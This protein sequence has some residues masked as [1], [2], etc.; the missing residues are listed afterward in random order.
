MP[1]DQ[2]VQPVEHFTHSLVSLFQSTVAGVE[3]RRRVAGDPGAVAGA[4]PAA[5]HGTPMM[6]S[7]ARAARTLLTLAPAAAAAS[8]RQGTTLSGID[9]CAQAYLALALAQAQDDQGA[10]AAARANLPQFGQCDPLWSEALGEFLLHASFRGRSEVP[11]VEWSSL[12]DFVDSGCLG[13]GARVAVISDWGT[14]EPR[15]GA[16]L[17]A[18]AACE[19]D[20]VIHLGDIYYSCDLREADA[21]YQNVTAPFAGKPTRIFSLCGN[22]DMYSGAAPYY[23]VVKRLGQPASFFCLRN[24]NWQLLAGDTGY[25]DYDPFTESQAIPG[26]RDGAPGQDN[27]YSELAWHVDK[28]ANAAGRKTVFMTHHPLFT[29]HAPIAGRYVCNQQLL[30]QLGPWL[31]DVALW[32]WGHEHAQVIYQPFAGLGR[33]RCMGSGAIPTLVSDAPYQVGQFDGSPDLPALLGD[34]G[35]RLR[36]AAGST[37]YDLGFGLLTLHGAAGCMTYYSFNETDGAVPVFEENL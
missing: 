31:G 11:Y 1:P 35:T 6:L 12:G 9:R 18:V 30:D 15:A 29:R 8:L 23:D 14:G 19:P 20:I 26:L 16:L 2:D 32:L 5:D 25:N 4:I 22:H 37:L 21:F 28:L 10:I 27:G 13:P 3:A 24:E 34:P 17:A 33:G 36:V 7:T